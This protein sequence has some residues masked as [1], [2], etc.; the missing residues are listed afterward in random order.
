MT[1]KILAFWTLGI[2]VLIGLTT[3][4]SPKNSAMKKDGDHEFTNQLIDESSPYLLQHA[5][6]PVNWHPWGEEALQKAKDENKLLIISI[7]YAACHW[8][9]VMEHESFEDSLVASIMNEHFVPIKVD[10]E[11]RP[12]VD[13]IYMTACQ[14]ISGSGGWPLNAFALPDG[15]PVWAGTYFPKDDWLNVLNQF[16]NLKESN[17]EKLEETARQLTKG[18]RSQDE[19]VKTSE[20]ARF[21]SSSTGTI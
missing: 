16:V 15:S 2:T 19:I 14:L 5:H 10:R 7:G 13:D 20:D 17:Y 1:Y 18:I 9:H 4:C 3:G 21:Q 8:C 11:E 6:N 12:D